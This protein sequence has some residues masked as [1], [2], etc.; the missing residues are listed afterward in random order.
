LNDRLHKF[1]VAD[2][3]GGA[4]VKGADRERVRSS[5]PPASLV[6]GMGVQNI[7]MRSTV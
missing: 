6:Y 7:A 4:G 1:I 5:P 2:D 3:S